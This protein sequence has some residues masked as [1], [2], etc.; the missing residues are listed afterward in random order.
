M[1]RLRL[2]RWTGQLL[3]ARPGASTASTP[4]AVPLRS[5]AAAPRCTA[6]AAAAVRCQSTSAAPQTPGEVDDFHDGT[7]PVRF[8]PLEQLPPRATSLPSPPPERAPQSA[9]LAALHARLSLPER[10]PLQTLA[11]ALVDASADENPQFNNTNLAF[12]GQSLINYHVAEWLMCRY[13]RLPMDILYAA[14]KAYAGPTALHHVARSWGVE[15]AAAPGGEVDP[16]LLQFSMHKPG[17]AI[18]SFGYRRAELEGIKKYKWRHGMS[19]RVVFDDDFG[20]MV[21]TEEARDELRS[22]ADTE[23]G[24]EYTR[25][26]AEKAYATCARAV[27]GAI[28]AHAGRE[29]AKAFIKAHILSRTLDLSR[30]FAFKKPTRELSLLCAREDFE[31]PVA[32]LLSETGRLSR[33]P[34]FV[35][36]I[37]SGK[38]K[39]GEA[40]GPSLEHARNKAAMNALKSWY[41]YSPGEHVRVPSDMLAEDAKPWEPAYIDIG[42]I[43]GR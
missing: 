11:R 5:A 16:G 33:T 14:M 26:L 39:L 41:L 38:D 4:R 15:H 29:A 30:L 7:D 1:K 43:I 23:Y 6:V 2:D 20:E 28:Y 12:V 18:V 35:V 13:P 10:L 37:F 8:P 32:R 9:K 19:S 42:E 36:G 24:N 3:L 31:P 27:T 22:R 17:D 40:A 21:D 25:S 34:V